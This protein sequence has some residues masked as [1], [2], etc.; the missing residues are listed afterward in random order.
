M[1]LSGY[2]VAEQIAALAVVA[3]R[4]KR[5][6]AA[7]VP[8]WPVLARPDQLPPAGD[9]WRTWLIL[10]GRGWGK[11]RTGAETVADWARTGKA[12]RIGV[13]AQTGADVRDISMAALRA[14]S[15]GVRY[16]PSKHHL[17]EW[18][19][20]ATAMGFS[21]EEP[22]SLRGY[23]FDTAWCD[24]LAAWQYPE[25]Y[26]QLQFGLRVGQT[27]Q[28][29]TTTPRPVRLIRML[30]ANPT[31]VVTRGRTEDNLANLSEE[32]FRDIVARYTGTRLGRQELDAEVLDDVPGALWTRR[33]FDERRPAPDMS[34]VVVAVDPA[35]SS[36]E[37]SD[38]TGIVVA[39]KGVDGRGYVLADRSCRLSPDGWA[40]RALDAWD[41]HSA[42]LIVAED[43]NGGEM[44]E[45]VLRKAAETDPR[46]RRAVIKRIHASR[47]KRTRAEPVS[48]LYEQGRVTHVAPF[49]DLE[50]QLCNWTPDSGESPD[51]L[52]A[53]VWALTELVVDGAEPGFIADLKA[54]AAALVA[55]A[56]APVIV[57]MNAC[58]GRVWRDNRLW[59]CA[60]EIGHRGAHT[61]GA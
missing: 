19:N 34:R 32:F 27:R 57:E 58:G 56:E 60:Q 31:C 55:E 11:T 54:R 18:P 25:A 9:D 53:L 3:A 17:I 2:P 23:E 15:P 61:E 47:G 51:R 52:D 40:R 7:A 12:R 35:A 8:G 22:D 59:P 36:N 46:Y 20:G 5:E 29:V 44:V 28:V 16:W 26:D 50:D 43:N 4:R 33:M 1:S 38:E 21:A 30:L 45:A 37:D 48:A 41:T 39:G 49:D 13:V 10:A 42:D 14:A 24:E 6:Q